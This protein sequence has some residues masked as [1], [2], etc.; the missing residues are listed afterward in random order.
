MKLPWEC[1]KYEADLRR[2]S[3]DQTS[4]DFLLSRTLLC[5]SIVAYH[6][7]RTLKVLS[8]CS[9]STFC[10]M[11]LV[12]SVLIAQTWQASPGRQQQNVIQFEVQHKLRE[13]DSDGNCAQC[14][15]HTAIKLASLLLQSTRKQQ[16]QSERIK[17]LWLVLNVV[18]IE[19]SSRLTMYGYGNARATCVSPATYSAFAFA[20]ALDALKI[21]DNDDDDDAADRVPF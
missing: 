20:V 1:I 5:F 12:P 3:H 13:I 7:H 4:F 8:P 15:T 16:Q 11:A 18:D 21:C 14:T 17:N 2:Q 19:S 9:R 10:Q 6:S